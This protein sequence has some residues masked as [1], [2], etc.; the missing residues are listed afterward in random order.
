ME[1]E[2]DFL[3]ILY[4][5]VCAISF[6]SY[7]SCK[8]LEDFT[9]Y[10]SEKAV[11]THS[12]TLAWKIPWTREPGGLQ[13]TGLRRVGHDW[14]TSLSRIGEGNGN[15][16]QCSCLEIPETGEP[17]GLPSMGSH[18]VGHDWSGLAAAAAGIICS[19][20]NITIT[21]SKE[22]RFESQHIW[23]FISML[24]STD[25]MTHSKSYNLPGP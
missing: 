2:Q 25:N 13:S 9:H 1:I 18:R 12:C 14:A 5:H 8:H 16:L 21:H 15:P 19:F 24:S 11:A 7:L 10:L 23:V 3:Q 22:Q 6:T 4:I 17:G 20:A